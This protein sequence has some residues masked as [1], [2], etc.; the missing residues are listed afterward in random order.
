M[1][2]SW[3]AMGLGAGL[4]TGEE[5]QLI[6]VKSE[7]EKSSAKIEF[8]FGFWECGLEHSMVFCHWCAILLLP[9]ATRCFGE[10]EDRDGTIQYSGVLN[11]MGQNSDEHRVQL[12]TVIC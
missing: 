12:H 6:G 1:R 2:H 7:T 4:A 11:C 10:L 5:N 3:A 9:R 8:D